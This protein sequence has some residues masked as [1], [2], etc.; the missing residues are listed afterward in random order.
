MLKICMGSKSD[1]E[2]KIHWRKSSEEKNLSHRKIPPQFE[3]I[4]EPQIAA[5]WEGI[6]EGILGI[7][8]FLSSSS[9]L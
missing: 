5:G 4:L 7:I 1:W 9:V 6:L 8:L 3:E 2:K